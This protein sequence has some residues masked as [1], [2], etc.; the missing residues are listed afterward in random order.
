M[1]TSRIFSIPRSFCR[2]SK[3]FNFRRS[4]C[5]SSKSLLYKEYGEPVNVLQLINTT[6]AQPADNEVNFN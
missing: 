4:N 3:S 5:T 1:Q 2:T 6:V